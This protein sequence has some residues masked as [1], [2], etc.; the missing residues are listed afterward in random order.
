MLPGQEGSFPLRTSPDQPVQCRSQS[1]EK[2]FSLTTA[3]S[4]PSIHLPPLIHR[5][6]Q[7]QK[8]TACKFVIQGLASS[9]QLFWGKRNPKSHLFQAAFS[10]ADSKHWFL[11][12]QEGTARAQPS[13]AGLLQK[14]LLQESGNCCSRGLKAAL[15]SR[16]QED[17]SSFYAAASSP[18]DQHFPL[19][20]DAGQ[21][22]SL[23]ARAKQELKHHFS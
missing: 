10:T 8:V 21:G 14:L 6:R 12:A 18:P 1:W 9:L 7:E 11:G 3:V 19:A 13:P 2:G 20:P 15:L 16:A 4:N 5:T 23:P 17:F 22:H